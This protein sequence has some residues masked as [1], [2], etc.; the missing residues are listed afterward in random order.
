MIESRWNVCLGWDWVLNI[1]LS[2]TPQFARM[3]I[4]TRHWWLFYIKTK[5]F[6][7]TPP[8]SM[9]VFELNYT[10]LYKINLHEIEYKIFLLEVVFPMLCFHSPYS[11]YSPLSL[12]PFFKNMW[13]IQNIQLVTQSDKQNNADPWGEVHWMWSIKCD[14]STISGH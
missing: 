7:V 6:F 4:P 9:M 10:C 14:A 3:F 1:G 13:R 8:L 12:H 5:I 2:V 11:F